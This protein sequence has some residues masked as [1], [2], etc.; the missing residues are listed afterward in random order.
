MRK[1]TRKI[2][3]NGVIAGDL[4]GHQ[5]PHSE[6]REFHLCLLSRIGVAVWASPG[7]LLLLICLGFFH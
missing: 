4:Q 6:H 7:G 1:G 3:W 5:H 2:R